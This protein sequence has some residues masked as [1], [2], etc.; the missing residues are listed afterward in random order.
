M[1]CNKIMIK[2]PTTRHMLQY[3]TIWQSVNN[4]FKYS[5]VIMHYFHNHCAILQIFHKQ[6]QTA[7]KETVIMHPYEL[8]QLL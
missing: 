2:N 5:N 4:L 3:I 1:P 7:R 6:Q 8:L